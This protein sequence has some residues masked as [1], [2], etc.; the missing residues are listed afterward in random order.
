MSDLWKPITLGKEWVEKKQNKTMK[1]GKDWW[2]LRW[3]KKPAFM[4]YEVEPLS[5][6]LRGV[7][8]GF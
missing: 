7:L 6:T 2:L 3:C 4:S 5:Q 8:W 1:E